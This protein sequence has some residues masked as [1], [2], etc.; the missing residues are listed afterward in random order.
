M[1]MEFIAGKTLDQLISR[2]GLRVNETLKYAV[3]V[4]DALATAHAAG[5]V[6]RDLKPGN[7]MVTDSGLAKVLDFGLAKLTEPAAAVDLEGTRTMR[8]EEQPHTDEG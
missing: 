7:V 6:H 1:V 3:Q 2:K 5:I 4:A 8:P